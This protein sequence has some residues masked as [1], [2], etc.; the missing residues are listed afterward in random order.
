M[1]IEMLLPLTRVQIFIGVDATGRQRLR[2]TTAVP[3]RADAALGLPF[4]LM[5]V[6]CNSLCDTDHQIFDE[7]V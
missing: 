7:R 3:D 4:V 2:A 5:T 1:P 6:V